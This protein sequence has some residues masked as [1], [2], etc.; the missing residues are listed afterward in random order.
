MFAHSRTQ[1]SCF[2]RTMRGTLD[3][4]QS[5]VRSC[6]NSRASSTLPYQ[7]ASAC[8]DQESFQQCTQAAWLECDHSQDQTRPRPR[9]LVPQDKDR[10]RCSTD[11]RRNQSIHKS[12][13]QKSRGTQTSLDLPHAS[14]KGCRSHP[15]RWAAQHLAHRQR[16]AQHH[17]WEP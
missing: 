9:A 15:A 3:R 5:Q 14:L 12:P 10:S 11:S 7:L 4:C 6:G 17:W 13:L 16:S 1:P 2:P 8:Q